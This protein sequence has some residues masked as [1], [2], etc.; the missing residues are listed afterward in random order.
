MIIVIVSFIGK[1]QVVRTRKPSEEGA[2]HLG[3]RAEGYDYLGKK[4][5]IVVIFVKELLR[6]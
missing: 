1:L 6:S 3:I 5:A 2:S 4:R